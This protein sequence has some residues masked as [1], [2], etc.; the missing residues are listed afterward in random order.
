MK[1]QGKNKVYEID[2]SECFWNMLVCLEE[3][4]FIGNPLPK[5]CIQNSNGVYVFFDVNNIPLRIGKAKLLRNRILSY[6]QNLNN[7]KYFDLFQSEISFVG[8]IYSKKIEDKNYCETDLIQSY[9]PIGNLNE[10]GN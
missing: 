8:V 7:H 1:L 6:S 4:S 10:L 9:K 5:D 2:T 3:K